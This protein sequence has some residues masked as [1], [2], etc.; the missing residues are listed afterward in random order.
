[1]EKKSNITER[2]VI[3][4]RGLLTCFGNG[5]DIC[6][7]KLK[8]NESGIREFSRFPVDHFISQ[9]AASIDG[10]DVS[11]SL[12]Y[13]M[14]EILLKD[15]LSNLPE[16]NCLIFST[17]TGEVDLLEKHIA[18]EGTATD[19]LAPGDFLMKVLELTGSSKGYLVSAACAS[20]S[21]AIIK[22]ALMI[23]KGIQDCILIIGCD[24]VS[25]FVF[26]GFSSLQA[27]ARYRAKPFDRDRDGLSLGEAA[28]Y[29]LL[30][31]EGRAARENREI[32][33]RVCGWGMTNDANHMTG[34]DKNGEGLSRS[35]SKSLS[36][37]FI[38]P[39]QV[40]SISAHG[41]GTRFNDSM[42]LKAF[43][44]IFGKHHVPVYSVKGGIGHTMGAAGLVE[45]ILCLCS[46]KEKLVPPVVNLEN[47]DE[48][49]EGWV[50]KESVFVEKPYALSTNSGFGGVNSAIVI[51][52][53]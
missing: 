33:G 49:A 43:K 17:T 51:K 30:M 19:G 15:R 38:T 40:G 42:E 7:E 10:L 16:D 37:A 36:S 13:Q 39:E 14:L 23:E 5:V 26:S 47:I 11:K 4:D 32:L 2:A 41:T 24:C 18:S 21:L 8:R 27:L 6:W 28:G 52:L 25:E 9:S 1:M 29:V 3:V 12:S 45:V 34:P 53:I 31:G 20:S 50:S 35:I 46:L 48:E 44:T 22:G